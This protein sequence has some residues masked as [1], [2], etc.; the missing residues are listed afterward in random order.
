MGTPMRDADEAEKVQKKDW[1]QP[2]IPRYTMLACRSHHILKQCIRLYQNWI[3]QTFRFRPKPTRTVTCFTSDSDQTLS[4]PRVSAKFYFKKV[5]W[6][7]WRALIQRLGNVCSK[8]INVYFPIYWYFLDYCQSLEIFL[9]ALII[10]K[11]KEVG[12]G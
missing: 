6:W 7:W 9:T 2:K 1:S 12:V 10:S 11:Y 4:D 3:T 8:W 5:F